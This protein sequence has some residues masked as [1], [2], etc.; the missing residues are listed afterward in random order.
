MQEFLVVDFQGYTPRKTERTQCSEPV[1][2]MV[3]STRFLW[4]KLMI[5]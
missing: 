2:Y 5:S 4:K 3:P 1:K